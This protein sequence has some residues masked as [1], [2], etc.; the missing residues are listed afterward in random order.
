MHKRYIYSI[1]LILF[2]AQITHAEI[3]TI[4]G[5]VLDN[6]QQPLQYVSIGIINK[7]IGT[8]SDAKGNFTLKIKEI[9]F[10]N[11]DSIRLSMIGYKS[12]TISLKEITNS[13]SLTIVLSQKIEKIAEAVII[14][15]KIKTKVKGTTHFPVPLYVQLVNSDLVNHNLGSAIARSVNINHDNTFIED[16]RFYIY[17]D[18]DTTTIRINVYDRKRKKLGKTLLSE[19]IYTQII[20]KKHDWVYVDL[21]PYNIIVNDD[22]IVSLEWVGKSKKGS[23][24]YFPLARPSAASHY[25][26][27]GSQ[28]KWDRWPNMSC[29]MELTLKY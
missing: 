3:T 24:L 25:Y 16:I 18:F 1:L 29:L 19:G 4:L 2:L 14:G 27:H 20:G 21:K 13:Q 9:H 6:K 5:R 15:N 10:N 11:N 23:Y 28:N 26:K 12:K 22:I 17:T 7:T 8:V